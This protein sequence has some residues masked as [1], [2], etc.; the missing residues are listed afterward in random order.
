MD[1]PEYF[2]REA[3]AEAAY[4]AARGYGKPFGAVVVRN[5]EII[6][7]GYNDVFRSNDPSAHA[8]LN[9][10]REAC[11]KLGQIT[12]HNC[13]LYATGQPCLMCL[14]AIFLAQLP[15]LYYA[16]SYT[17][18]EALGYFGGKGVACMA[19]ALGL[20]ADNF[21]GD[22]VSSRALTVTRLP[23]PEALD[24]YTQWKDQGKSL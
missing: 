19:C 14:A 13:E 9:A 3:V 17:D 8:E 18:A 21:S 5:G 6:G 23:L 20:A 4:S 2:M 24:L 15:V 1:S 11:K 7:R 10:I 12:L 22:F 16:N